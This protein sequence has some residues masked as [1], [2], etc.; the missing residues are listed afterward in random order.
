[1]KKVI[2]TIIWTLV[3]GAALLA[4]KLTVLDF[5]S[6]YMSLASYHEV[7]LISTDGIFMVAGALALGFTATN[8]WIKGW[9]FDKD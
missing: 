7:K 6:K 3:I 1:M 9:L 2:C 8:V 5:Y 4:A